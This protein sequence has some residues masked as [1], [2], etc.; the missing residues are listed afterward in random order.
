MRP[1]A[2]AIATVAGIGRIPFAPGTWGSAAAIPLAWGAHYL[3]GFPLVVILTAAVTALGYWASSV[4]L[5]GRAEDPSEI[6]IDEVA[7]ML[8][9][10]WPLSVGLTMSGAAPHI[11]PWPGWFGGFVICQIATALIGLR[12]APPWRDMTA[13]AVT[14]VIVLIGAGASHGWFS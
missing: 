14:I 9:A 11:F 8:V 13:G 2:S 7:G 6:V 12:L 10:L 5:D 1:L 4:Y 3:G